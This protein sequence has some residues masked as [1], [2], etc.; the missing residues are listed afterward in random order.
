MSWMYTLLL[1]LNFFVPSCDD[2]YRGRVP[3]DLLARGVH[4]RAMV[5]AAA[6]DQHIREYD[7]GGGAPG[8]RSV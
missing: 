6:A 2:H 7:M 4:A 8:D 3:G 5:C 1:P